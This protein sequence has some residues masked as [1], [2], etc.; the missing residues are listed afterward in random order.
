MC[1]KCREVTGN[2]TANDR[3][4]CGGYLKEARVCSNPKCPQRMIPHPEINIC[5][6]STC[7]GKMIPIPDESPLLLKDSKIFNDFEKRDGTTCIRMITK[8]QDLSGTDL[9][10]IVK[11][12]DKFAHDNVNTRAK[13]KL[14][15]QNNGYKLNISGKGNDHRCDWCETFGTK[16]SSY[17]MDEVDGIVRTRRTCEKGF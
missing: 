10:H 3:C 14:F 13:I 16:L 7:N 15:P 8:Y 12:A 9:S 5:F 11:T 1:T 2:K 6:R 17:T 4:N